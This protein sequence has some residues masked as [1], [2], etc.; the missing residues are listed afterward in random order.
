MRIG[1]VDVDSHNY[2][3]FALMKIS[4]YHKAKGDYVEIAD[5]KMSYDRVYQSKIFTFTPDVDTWK[6]KNVELITGGTGYSVT[7]KLPDKIENFTEMDYSIYPQHPFSIQFF[8]RGCIRNCPFCLVKEKEGGIKSVEPVQLNP[9]GEWVE[10]LDNNFFANTDWKS[11]V[12]YL[13]DKKQPVN[14]HGVDIRIMNEEQAFWL[15][16][17]PLKKKIH[18][19]WDLPEIDLTDKLKE[20]VRYINPS[21]LMCYVLVGFNSSIQDDLYRI[22]RLRE[23]GILPFVM[24]YRDFD[25]KLAKNQYAMDLAR[26]CNNRYIFKSCPRFRDYVPRK[27]FNCS[28]YFNSEWSENDLGIIIPEKKRKLKFGLRN[29]PVD[30]LNSEDA[31]K[32]YLK[33]LHEEHGIICKK[34]GNKKHYWKGYKNGW[35]CT[36]C[37]YRTSLTSRTIMHKTR[38]PLTYWFYSLYQLYNNPKISVLELQR[39]LGHNRYEP[40]W[41]MVNK[42]QN[43]IEKSG[44]GKDPLI[45]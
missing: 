32:S 12:D 40:I 45:F 29:I 33:Q 26:W 8:S 43:A 10:V 27:N 7:S 4:A 5:P 3:N 15:N 1:I 36:N 11:A 9:N 14:L 38:L 28:Y 2:P 19:A 16:K 35:E 13:I 18:I 17:L 44:E 21:K 23:L 6:D 41:L 20:I 42:L 37:S 31:C 22:Y 30:V 39:S 34:C 24:P 25:N